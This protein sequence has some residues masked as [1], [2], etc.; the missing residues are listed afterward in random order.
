MD[1]VSKV[2]EAAIAEKLPADRSAAAA[3]FSELILIVP[4]RTEK[5]AL[6]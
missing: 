1:P 6:R 4:P 2:A 3:S 5:D